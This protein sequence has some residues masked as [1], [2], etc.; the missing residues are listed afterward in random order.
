LIASQRLQVCRTNRFWFAESAAPGL[1]RAWLPDLI[2][3][4]AAE[5]HRATVLHYDADY[6]RIAAVTGQPT[7]WVIPNG[8]L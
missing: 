7:E 6:D 3:A 2:V 5:L 8:S 1:P 4:A